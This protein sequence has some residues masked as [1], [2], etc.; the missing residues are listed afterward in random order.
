M[1]LKGLHGKLYAWWWWKSFNKPYV[2]DNRFIEYLRELPDSCLGLDLGSGNRGSVNG[3]AVSLDISFSARL[4]V[5]GDARCLPFASSV[6]DYVWC[7][8]VLEHVTNPQ[9]VAKEIMR[10]LKPDGVL[11]LQ[12][13]FLENIHSWPNDYFR[14]TPQGIRMLFKEMKEESWGISAGPGQV[15]SDLVQYYIVLFADLQKRSVWSFCLLLL[16]FVPGLLLVP[17]K[18]M[19]KVLQHRPTFMYWARA[20]YFVARKQ[21]IGCGEIRK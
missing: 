17:L 12:V 8:A 6:F 18:L 1:R 10:V 19:D 4:D 3:K 20:F 15:I 9:D 2:L 21:R 14:F 7:N 5:V 13:P 16:L 11:I